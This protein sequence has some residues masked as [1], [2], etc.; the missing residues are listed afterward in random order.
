MTPGDDHLADSPSARQWSVAG[1]GVL[2]SA[3][4]LGH[5]AGHPGSEPMV[6][7]ATVLPAV[8]LFAYGVWFWQRGSVRARGDAVLVWAIGGAGVVLALDLWAML[9]NAY[10]AGAAVDHVFI[11]HTS[12]GAL[13][14]AVA[15]TYSERDRWRA[16]SHVRL[17]RAL[18]AAMDGIAVIRDD[19]TISYANDAFVAYYEADAG[20]PVVGEDWRAA[21]PSA[22]RDRIAD[23][24]DSF[25][26]GDRE[27]WQ[28]TVTAR[29]SDGSTYP[30]DLSMT[31]LADG[32]YVWVCRDVSGREERDQR[33]R[34]L[35][36]VLRHNARNALNVVLGRADRLAD[37]LGD[38]EDVDGIVAAAEDLLAVSEKARRLEQALESDDAPTRPLAAV[39]KDEL[40]RVRGEYADVAFRCELD[41][42]RD[43]DVRLRLAVRELLANAAEHNDADDPVVSVTVSADPPAIRVDDNGP[44]IPEH[45]RRALAGVE[46]TRL[47][48][49]SGVGLW[50]VY[51]LVSQ[52]GGDVEVTDDDAVV[53][54]PT[55][56]K[57]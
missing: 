20:G 9:V 17:R 29:R 50:L 12:V 53:L 57:N 47:E 32:G 13:G 55:A 23:V 37:R 19:G 25:E 10:G 48:H 5:F 33:L 43:V 56:G 44:A 39:V 34:V 45:E 26:A 41:C 6:A 7:A 46:E 11:Q 38:D 36:R 14:G 28:G 51:W 18:D 4:A 21:Y 42:E 30:Q 16:R 54:R 8:A 27:Q 40:E 3:A 35:N 15:G 2:L 49:G 52:T 24:L 1:L 22:A 31:A